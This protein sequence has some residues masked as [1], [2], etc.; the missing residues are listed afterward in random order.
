MHQTTN[1]K[2]NNKLT[3]TKFPAKTS[4]YNHPSIPEKQYKKFKNIFK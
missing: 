4:K 2:N 3:K 1:S